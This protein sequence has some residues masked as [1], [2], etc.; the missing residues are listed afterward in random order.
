MKRM[1]MCWCVRYLPPAARPLA[2]AMQGK[3][4]GVQKAEARE[5]P[6]VFACPS[7]YEVREREV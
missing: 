3:E 6:Y 4:Q 7:S 5:L 2:L 1:T